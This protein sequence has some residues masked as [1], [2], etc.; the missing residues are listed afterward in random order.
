M[1]PL[2]PYV[3]KQIQRVLE[4]NRFVEEA[5]HIVKLCQLENLSSI[6]DFG[7]WTGVLGLE[8][9]KQWP[10]LEKYHLIDAVPYYLDKAKTMLKEFPITSQTVTLIPSNHK[11]NMPKSMLIKDRKSTRLNSSHT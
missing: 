8:I 4:N 7:C 5:T 1:H 6:I 11:G 2:D 9:F 10:E 3:D